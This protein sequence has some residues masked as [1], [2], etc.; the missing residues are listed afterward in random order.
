M[1]E[2]ILK[3]VAL[4]FVVITDPERAPKRP[5]AVSGMTKVLMSLSVKSLRVSRK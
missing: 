4:W 1:R 3:N 5:K 2:L